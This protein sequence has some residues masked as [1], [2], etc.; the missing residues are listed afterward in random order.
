MSKPPGLTY[1][2]CT[3]PHATDNTQVVADFIGI[4]PGYRHLPAIE[5]FTLQV[6]VGEHPAGSTISRQ[7]LEHH[8]YRL[9][10]RHP[11][12]AHRRMIFTRVDERHLTPAHAA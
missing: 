9:G 1:L 2:I 3:M 12:P 8:G 5:L 6:G 4:Q 7:T 11:N 10:S